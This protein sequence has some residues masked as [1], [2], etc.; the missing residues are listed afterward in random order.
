MSKYIL[1]LILAICTLSLSAQ[2][3]SGVT[4]SVVIENVLSDKGNIL[5]GLYTKDNFMRGAGVAD[6]AT[7]AKAGELSFEFRN[8]NPGVYA[9]TVMQ[10]FNNNQRMDFEASGMP[11]EPYGTSGNSIAMGPPNFQDSQFEVGKEDLEIRIRF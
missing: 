3:D 1:T 6:Y 4:I 8:V 11:V 2:E 5:A 7:E 10:D 9:I